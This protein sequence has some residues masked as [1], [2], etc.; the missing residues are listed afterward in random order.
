MSTRIVAKIT[1]R[2]IVGFATSF[3]VKNAIQQNVRTETQLQ[4]AG[5]NIGSTAVGVVVAEETAAYTD[6]FVDLIFDAFTRKVE[7]EEID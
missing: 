4:K 6:R 1:A 7:A 2:T 3:T 5:V